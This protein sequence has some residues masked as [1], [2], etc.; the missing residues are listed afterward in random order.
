MSSGPKPPETPRLI[1]GKCHEALMPGKVTVT[2]LGNTFPL[3][4]LKCPVCGVA[5][6]PESLAT[7]KMLTVEQAL[8][9]K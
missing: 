5:F 3:E 7:G 1:C 9:D 4:L 2:Y 8:E 6:V